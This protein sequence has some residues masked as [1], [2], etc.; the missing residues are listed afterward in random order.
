MERGRATTDVDS[1]GRPPHTARDAAPGVI[2]GPPKGE[3]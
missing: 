3:S 2:A 1:E